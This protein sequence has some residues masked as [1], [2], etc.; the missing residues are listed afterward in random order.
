MIPPELIQAKQ[1]IDTLVDIYSKQYRTKYLSNYEW[2]NT[3]G[4]LKAYLEAQGHILRA[5]DALTK[6]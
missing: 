3:Y 5:I 4:C 6:I 2:S 1:T